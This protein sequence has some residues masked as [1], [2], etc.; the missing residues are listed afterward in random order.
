V[1][2][3]GDG[4]GVVGGFQPDIDRIDL[5]QVASLNSFADVQAAQTP[6]T[7]TDI[8]SGGGDR[9]LLLD[10]AFGALDEDDFLF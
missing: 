3:D 4:V 6:S 9:I 7:G 10:Q 8:D 1:F 5:R 2:V